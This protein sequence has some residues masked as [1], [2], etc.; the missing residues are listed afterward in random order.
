MSSL[1]DFVLYSAR[2]RKAVGPHV[3]ALLQAGLSVVLD[4][5]ANTVASRGW[6]RGLADEAEAAHQLHVLD[7][8]DEVCLARLRGRNAEGTHPFAVTEAQFHQ[9]TR[10][11]V[12]PT[13][14]EGLD[15]VLHSGEA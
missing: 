13:A 10:H 11:F 2:L 9:V 1:Q 15:V 4:F 7:V 6:M 12:L 3:V 14:D 8:P 5:Q